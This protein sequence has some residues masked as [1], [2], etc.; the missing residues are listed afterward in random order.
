MVMRRERPC[1]LLSANTPCSTSDHRNEQT[2]WTK[3][4]ATAKSL[5][6][7]AMPAGIATANVSHTS[8]MRRYSRGA[9]SRRTGARCVLRGVASKTE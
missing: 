9:T 8:T 3:P 7:S 4:F 1:A 5:L 6:N 2:S